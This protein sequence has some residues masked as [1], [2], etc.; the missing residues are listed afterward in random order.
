MERL[1]AAELVAMIERVFEPQQGDERVVV[2]VDLP[3]GELPDNDAW[4]LR[5]SIA[6]DW[7]RELHAARG[8]HRFEVADRV[9]TLL[10]QPQGQPGSIGGGPPRWTECIGAQVEDGA[11]ITI[12]ERLQFAHVEYEVT[13]AGPGHQIDRR[14]PHLLQLIAVHGAIDLHQDHLVVVQRRKLYGHV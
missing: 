6:A 10:D 13:E 4:A 12:L 8:D 5:R 9:V 11:R 14:P 3:D 2:L 7:V 1:K